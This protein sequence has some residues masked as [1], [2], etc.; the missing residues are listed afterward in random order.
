MNGDTGRNVA[1]RY[2]LSLALKYVAA[3]PAAV[4]NG[5]GETV[6]MSGQELAYLAQG[7]ACVGDKVALYIEWPVLLQDEV[8]LQL[9]VTAQIVQRSGLLN[10][11]KMTRHEFRTR[12]AR[13]SAVSSRLGLS[14]TMWNGLSVQ[15]LPGFKMP[16]N[17]P[18]R[19]PAVASA[20]GG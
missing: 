15:P 8:P 9:I 5:V 13:S 2:P 7:P 11:A 4:R 17:T 12:G 20:A 3:W 14:S 16:G 19:Q 6:W 10:I 18:Q 1:R